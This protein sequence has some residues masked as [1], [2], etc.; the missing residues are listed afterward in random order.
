MTVLGLDVGS[1]SVKAGILRDGKLSGADATVSRAFFPTRR[2]R[3]RVEVD[4][5]A[6]QRALRA[7]PS[8]PRVESAQPVQ[9]FQV[10][11]QAKAPAQTD[12]DPLYPVQPAKADWRLDE[13]HKVAT[14]KGV[15]V[16]VIDSGVATEHPDLRGQVALARNFVDG[17]AMS[18]EAHGTEVAGLIAAREGNGVGLPPVT[19]RDG[20]VEGR[21]RRRVRTTGA[22]HAHGQT[23]EAAPA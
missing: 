19:A 10:L 14:G 7:L 4:P 23:G 5:A 15:T 2:I 8:D 22:A 1:S 21:G 6:V 16:A 9:R 18:G 3:E 13:L 11:A 17:R 20:A 12:A